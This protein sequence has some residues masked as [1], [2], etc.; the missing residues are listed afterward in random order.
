MTISQDLD[1]LHDGGPQDDLNAE[2]P[3]SELEPKSK[4]K[5]KAK[6]Q[7]KAKIKI[8]S[9]SKPETEQDV[10][11]ESKSS[12][13]TLVC[14]SNKIPK[15]QRNS[16]LFQEGT[17]LRRQGL[18]AQ[19]IY[20][21]LCEINNKK[22]DP[23]LD[24][25]EVRQIAQSAAK[26]PDGTIEFYF[27]HGCYSVYRK[28]VFF[29]SSKEPS[30]ATWLCTQIIPYAEA[31]NEQGTEWSLFMQIIDKDGTEHTVQIPPEILEDD[32]S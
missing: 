2:Q 28:G 9:K 31:R 17:I 6:A 12:K 29:Y 20:K 22:C 18:N 4:A 8:K 24:E 21:A 19:D 5:A 7:A 16:Y 27:P 3:Q 25:K 11:A 30:K 32:S 13:G 14:Y 10:T 1:S 23:P 15:G 26:V